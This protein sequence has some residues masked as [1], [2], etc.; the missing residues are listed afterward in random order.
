MG[1]ICG[2]C[3]TAFITRVPGFT[4]IRD[5]SDRLQEAILKI[6]VSDELPMTI[7]HVFYTLAGYGYVHKDDKG[8]DAVIYQMGI[9]RE[10]GQLPYSW[11]ADN[12][13]WHIKPRTYSN[14]EAA[15]SNTTETYRRALWETQPVYVEIWCEKD[16]IAS[17]I[18]SVTRPYDVPLYV[19]RGFS[20]KTGLYNIAEEIRELKKPAYIYQFGDFDPSGISAFEAASRTL[21]EFVSKFGGR[22][23]LQRVAVTPEQIA[24]W[25]LPTRP[26]KKS[27][28]ASGWGNKPSVELDVIPPS[29]L[30]ELARECIEKHI[31][32]GELERIKQIEQQERGALDTILQ[33]FRLDR[34]SEAEAL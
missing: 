6:L 34:N 26:T 4:N 15:L 12:T 17:I 28:H 32:R 5:K 19:A 10:A 2:D 33:N 27:T 30:R 29:K 22:V 14:L 20:S 11:L 13:R 31:D 21:R 7:R 1:L 16:A 23:E 25:N 18:A 3:G 9:M 24:E 8:Y